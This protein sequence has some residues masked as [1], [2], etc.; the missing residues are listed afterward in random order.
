MDQYTYLKV[1]LHSFITTGRI[2]LNLCHIFLILYVLHLVP[3]RIVTEDVTVTLTE[4]EVRIRL[5]VS[6][7]FD[8]SS[9]YVINYGKECFD[10]IGF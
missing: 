3:D 9:F 2:K 8:A 5:H 1:S 4:S 10:F 7:Q 6:S